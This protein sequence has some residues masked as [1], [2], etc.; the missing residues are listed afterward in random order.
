MSDY[1]QPHVIGQPGNARCYHTEPCR[2]VQKAN[3]EPTP[4]PQR[5]V[6]WHDLEE[7][8]YC[9][10]EWEGHGKGHVPGDD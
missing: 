10:G 9:A 2:S 5:T 7:C 8:A 3:K 6:E 1:D 4:T